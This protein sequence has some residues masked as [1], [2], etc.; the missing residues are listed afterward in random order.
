MN[1]YEVTFC[2]LDESG[3]NKFIARAAVPAK[4]SSD[5][6]TLAFEFLSPRHPSINPGECM[7]VYFQG[8]LVPTEAV[9]L[10]V[11]QKNQQP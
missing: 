8:A 1:R 5:A 11:D 4:T 6:K 7:S 3:N 2:A 9:E 10:S